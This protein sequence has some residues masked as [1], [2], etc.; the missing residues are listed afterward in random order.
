[1]C[2]PKEHGGV[3]I[4]NTKI[5]N[6]CLIKKWAWKILTG[7]GGLWLQIYRKKYIAV[8]EGT[9]RSTPEKSRFAKAIRKVEP[10]LCLGTKYTIRDGTLA[11]F[12]LTLGV[13]IHHSMKDTHTYL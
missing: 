12:G 9:G 8:D 2:S 3:G 4:I 7:Q 1:M 13:R 6:W 5:M 11:L 10:L